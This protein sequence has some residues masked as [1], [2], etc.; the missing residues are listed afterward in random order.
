MRVQS[1]GAAG[2]RRALRLL[3]R[4]RREGQRPAG[5]SSARRSCG[6]RRPASAT[7]SCA[8]APPARS[9]ATS[10]AA[11]PRS[12]R[13][14]CAGATGCT[15]SRSP[16]AAR[17]PPPSP[18][19]TSSG[20]GP[21]TRRRTAARARKVPTPFLRRELARGEQQ[22]ALG[23]RRARSRAVQGR[24][25]C[26][27]SISRCRSSTPATGAPSTARMRSSARRPA[28]SAGEPGI[29]STTSTARSRPDARAQAR[30]ERPGARGDADPG[31]AHAA[32]AHQL[33]TTTRRVVALTGHGEPEP[34]A[35]DRGVDPDDAP[36]AVDERAAGV[37]RVERRVGLDHVVDHAPGVA[38]ADRQRAAERGDDARGHRA[39]E[40]VRVA[41][42][43]DELA[44][45]QRR[46]VAQLGGRR[47][48]RARSAAA[49]GRV[50]GSAPT[51]SRGELAAVGEGGDDARRA[52]APRRRARS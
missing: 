33:A 28:R 36:A 37:A 34:D 15:A 45:A 11:R 2:R 17:S 16:S 48:R 29:T 24:P 52:G 1:G 13:P 43:D 27:P 20:A 4:H 35:R 46:G 12:P 8:T 6:A 9:P 41:D 10:S 14:A 49:R 38:V 50:S 30:R 22:L 42:R 51:S 47:A 26:S 44:D 39:R 23:S 31:A 3:H 18:G 7:A 32:V 25:M 5:S 19:A 40:A 21:C